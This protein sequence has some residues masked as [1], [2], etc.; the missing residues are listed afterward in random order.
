MKKSA[1]SPL[2]FAPSR[3]F[4]AP[5]ILSSDICDLA[6]HLPVLEREAEW[7][8]L[9][10][11]DGCFV[12]NISFGFPIIKSIRPKT[13]MFFDAHLMIVNPEWYFERFAEAGSGAITF[14]LEAVEKPLEALKQIHSLG[15]RA[16]ISLNDETPVESVLPFLQ[17]ADLVLVMGAPAGFGGQSL[18]PKNIEKIRTLRKKIDSKK[19]STLVSVDCGVNGETGKA[20]IEAGVD[21]LVMGSAV[22]KSEKPVEELRKLQQGLGL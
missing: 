20:V 1:S 11:M 8:H 3:S 2:A 22:F 5:S 19:L 12:P 15:K 17:E 13:R 4:I 14:H 6:K 18:Q 16:G 7:L 21:I 10:V 9:D